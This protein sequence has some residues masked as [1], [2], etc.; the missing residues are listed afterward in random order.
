MDRL[1]ARQVRTGGRLVVTADAPRRDDQLMAIPSLSLP[2]RRTNPSVT[3][4]AMPET[5]VPALGGHR[6]RE[7]IP[8]PAKRCTRA[9][10]SSERLSPA[11]PGHPGYPGTG[12]PLSRRVRAAARSTTSGTVIS[13]RTVLC[14]LA[15][16]HDR[17]SGLIP[18]AFPVL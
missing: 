15:R 3:S 11:R 2:A 18:G 9:A 4:I 13:A 5:T 10:R 1:Q 17:R 16:V 6:A 14:R 8:A 12:P 7:R